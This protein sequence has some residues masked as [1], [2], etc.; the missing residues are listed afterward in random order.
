VG[1]LLSIRVEDPVGRIAPA[2][3]LQDD[4]I[5]TRYRLQVHAVALRCEYLA[6]RRPEDKDGELASASR[7]V[8]VGPQDDA[9]P[10]RY[11]DTATDWDS[12]RRL[13]GRCRSEPNGQQH[14]E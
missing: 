1:T 3:I 7:P 10:H 12:R 14:A 11:R 8:D 9:V 13:R 4:R 6:V 5:A 2:H